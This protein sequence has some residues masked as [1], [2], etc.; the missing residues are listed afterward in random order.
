M[1]QNVETEVSPDGSA[2][3][4]ADLALAE[5]LNEASHVVGEEPKN[6]DVAD[7]KD[8]IPKDAK[9]SIPEN[10]RSSIPPPARSSIVQPQT[11][12]ETRLSS[13]HVTGTDL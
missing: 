10:G 11:A 2:V 8:S 6:P 1:A 12:S 5:Q 7:T 4:S 9:K 13:D 3:A